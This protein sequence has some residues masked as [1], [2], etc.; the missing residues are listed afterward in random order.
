[1]LRNLIKRLGHGTSTAEQRDR[2]TAYVSQSV[3]R[4]LLEKQQYDR[5]ISQALADDTAPVSKRIAQV[6][7][8]RGLSLDTDFR[9]NYA[10][11]QAL[12]E[13][14]R[15]GLL[16]TVR[17]VAII[18]PGLDFIDKDSGF[19]HYPLQMLQPFAVADSLLRLG[20]ADLR[21]LR[22]ALFDISP[23]TLDHVAQALERARARQ[24]YTIQ[25]VLD[26]NRSWDPAVSRYWSQFGTRIGEGASAL[27]LPPGVANMDRRALR[28]RPEVVRL[29][30]PVSLNVVVE[31]LNQTAGE[32]FDLVVAT[33]V[34]VYYDSFEQSLAL[35]NIESMLAPG[36]IFLSNDF[37]DD[38]RGIRLRGVGSI[39]V[40][41]SPGQADQMR[42][43]SVPAFQPQLPPP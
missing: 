24:P 8:D 20:L 41:Y 36:G 28:I 9:P 33:N 39:N 35:L 12:S 3:S 7:K 18:G 14:R 37:F 21:N 38:Y 5:A 27:P 29:M 31:H 40:N 25:V 15:R 26:R 11:E 34:F 10:I 1:L 4:Y 22:L 43:L 19:D 30:D 13:V 42:I 16:K 2:L 6:Y 23:H 17:R 32:R